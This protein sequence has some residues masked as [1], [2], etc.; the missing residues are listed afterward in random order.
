[1]LREF[2]TYKLNA[3]LYRAELD[4]HDNVIPLYST[5]DSS[6]I[7]IGGVVLLIIGYF[8]GVATR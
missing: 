3:D 6:K 8:I 5:P 4:K 2:Q 7:V 1:M